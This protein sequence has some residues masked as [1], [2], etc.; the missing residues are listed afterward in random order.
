MDVS[1]S[2]VHGVDVHQSHLHILA[3]LGDDEDLA[4]DLAVRGTTHGAEDEPQSQGE[5]RE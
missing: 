4:G 3:A 5:Q 2:A 1:C